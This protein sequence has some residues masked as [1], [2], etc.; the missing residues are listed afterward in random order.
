VFHMLGNQPRQPEFTGGLEAARL[1][2]WHA[3]RLRDL[4]PKQIFFA[5]DTPDD[6]DPLRAA[7]KML[8]EAGFTRGTHTLRAYVLIGYPGDTFERA[9]KR[10]FETVDAGFLPMA[11]LYRD[12]RGERAIEWR[13]FQ[14]QW[15]RPVLIARRL[16]ADATP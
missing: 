13:R 12:K 8:L 16:H 9:E 15:A 1:L 2:P 10:L 3:E 14:R 7:G 5:Y 11:M 4:R 6:L